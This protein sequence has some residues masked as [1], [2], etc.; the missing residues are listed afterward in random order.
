MTEYHI[1]NTSYL[2]ALY[3]LNLLDA[4]FMDKQVYITERIY[5]ELVEKPLSKIQQ[6]KINSLRKKILQSI[7][8]FKTLT[9]HK[10][11]LIYSI[12][13]SKMSKLLEL[14]RHKIAKLEKKK[15]DDVKADHTIIALAVQLAT[16][17]RK[18]FF[19]YSLDKAINNILSKEI[20]Q[21]NLKIIIIDTLRDLT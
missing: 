17:G 7:N 19:Y 12:E 15:I 20:K 4:F 9:E 11:L 10:K 21:R 3:R 6:I 1:A 8:K 16:K 13:Y 2:I 18:I 5:S 14:Y